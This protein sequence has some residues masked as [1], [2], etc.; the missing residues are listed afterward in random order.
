[1]RRIYGTQGYAD[2]IAQPE[3]L[4]DEKSRSIAMTLHVHEGQQYHVKSFEVRGLDSRTT[5]LLE[6]RMRPGSIFNAPLLTDLFDEGQ[7]A[8]GAAASLD[9]VVHLRRNA[10]EGSVDI[11]LDFSPSA[12]GP[13]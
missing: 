11:L 7:L 13:N 5:T 8:T 4:L 12:P 2:M 1:M 3:F 6:T 10:A 9:S